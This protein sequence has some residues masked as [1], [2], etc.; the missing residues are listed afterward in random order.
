[1][2]PDICFLVFAHVPHIH[3]HFGTCTRSPTVIL[4]ELLYHDPDLIFDM[5]IYIFNIY[6]INTY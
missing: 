4:W 6:Y 3:Q 5:Y 1:M 2:M